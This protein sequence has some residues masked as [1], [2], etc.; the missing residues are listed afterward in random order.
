MDN[1][2]IAKALFGNSG[3]SGSGSKSGGQTTTVYGIATGDS[4]N[5]IVRVNL[6]GETTSLDDDQ[7]L[8][9]ETTFAV[10]EGDEVIVSLVGADGTGKSPCVIGVVGRGDEQQAQINSVINYVWDDERGLHVS[11]AERSVQGANILLDSDSLDIRNG[12]SDSEAD[13]TVYASFGR[14]ITVGTRDAGSEVGTYSQ[15]YGQDCVASAP[16]S[17]AS[18]FNTIAASRYQTVEGRNNV[19]DSADLYAFIIGNGSAPMGI[20][21]FQ[22]DGV[23]SVF[24]LSDT[25]VN[26]TDIYGYLNGYSTTNI[27]GTSLQNY[28]TVDTRDGKYWQVHVLQDLLSSVVVEVS[29]T[30]SDGYTQTITETVQKSGGYGYWVR[31]NGQGEY[32][33][34][35]SV[36]YARARFTNYPLRSYMSLSGYDV[37]ISDFSTELDGLNIQIVYTYEG[38]ISRSNGFTVD[39]SGNTFAAGEYKNAY[40]TSMMMKLLWENASPSSNFAAQHIAVDIKNYSWLCIGAITTINGSAIAYTFVKV[41]GSATISVPNLGSTQYF[42][43]RTAT[44]IDTGSVGVDFSTGYR[45][46]D[47][48]TG[49]QYCI[50]VEIY[51]VKFD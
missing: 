10:F 21:T 46:T 34:I 50:P 45:N 14:E 16:F 48:T 38:S 12:N 13:Q 31:V 9:V 47:S 26:I 43:K 41:G 32:V 27:L 33:D 3:G 40:G 25:Q 7:T 19:E 36:N 51:G 42:Y 22:T 18:G 37:T 35:S 29:T 6:G 11:T 23:T 24:S 20:E 28:I 49:T 17:K 44:A 39:W 8:E 1:L 4:V 15:V 30:F 2:E 5:G